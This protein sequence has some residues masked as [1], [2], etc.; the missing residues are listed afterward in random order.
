[1]QK[2]L[3]MGLR[4][5]KGFTLVELLV[6]I[7]IIG[8][9]IALLLPAV[10]QAREAARRMQCSNNLKQIGLALHN[11]HD[12]YGALPCGQVDDD[13]DSFAWSFLLLPQM[14]QGNLFEQVQNYTNGSNQ[15][16]VFIM[17]G[18]R[19]RLPSPE[20]DPNSSNIDTCGD[21]SR[22]RW[23]DLNN[24]LRDSS[25]IIDG[26]LCPSDVL[27]AQDDEGYAK[28]NYLGNMGWAFRDG[29]NHDGTEQYGCASFSGSRQNGILRFDNQNDT[30]YMTTFAEITD[31]LSNTVA[32]GE[33]SESNE[34]RADNT[35]TNRYP[36]MSGGNG[37]GC[38]G[39]GIAATMRLMD[40]EFFI[41][42]RDNTFYSDLSYGSKHP[43]GAQ[44]LLADG[45]VHFV[46][47]TVQVSVYRAMGSRNDGVAFEL[48]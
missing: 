4:K 41:N 46:P 35:G 34:I 24:I 8:V 19:H 45:S 47:E 13:N 12:T 21:R 25:S 44:F 17:K 10:Q 36:L 43:G 39:Q 9:L 2:N 48:P 30:T 18:G 40:S 3:A 26:Y 16:P 27:P 38:N 6:V 14:E 15:S 20:C 22:N 37:A 42:R 1:M 33:V 28:N 31:G 11:F 29:T 23:G 7:A 5:P 32:V